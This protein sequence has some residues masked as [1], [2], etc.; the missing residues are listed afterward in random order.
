[1]SCYWCGRATPLVVC[2]EC[3]I[4]DARALVP[5]YDAEFQPSI[6]YAVAISRL[7]VSLASCGIAPIDFPPDEPEWFDLNVE[8]FF[9]ELEH[10]LPSSLAPA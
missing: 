2:V 4:D 9:S 10:P 8:R 6:T 1:M 7:R 5:D 3:R